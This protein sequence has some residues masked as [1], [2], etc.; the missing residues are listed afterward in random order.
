MSKNARLDLVCEV[1][2][3]QQAN[4]VSIEELSAVFY[5]IRS[6]VMNGAVYPHLCG[7]LEL[8]RMVDGSGTCPC[9]KVSLST[10]VQS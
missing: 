4:S 7:H 1:L 10:E 3:N 9:G 5:S 2:F 6:K 8:L